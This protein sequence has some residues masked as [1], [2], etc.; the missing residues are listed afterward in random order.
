MSLYRWFF[1]FFAFSKVLQ[2]QVEVSDLPEFRVVD[3]GGA[4]DRD[5]AGF[6]ALEERLDRLYERHRFSVYFVIYSGIIGGTAAEKA[7]DLR[8]QWL[9][10]GVEGLVFVSDTDLG[11]VSFA[12]TNENA[13]ST[14]KSAGAWIL[15]DHLV[16]DA[17]DTALSGGSQYSKESDSAYLRELG[18]VLADELEARLEVQGV[19]RGAS[20]YYL[21]AFALTMLA[22]LGVW[23]LVRRGSKPRALIPLPDFKMN[24]RLGAQYGGGLV[25]EIHYNSGQK[26]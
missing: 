13:D 6:D 1:L 7:H 19:T 2:A 22:M 4:F 9:P 17:I 8:D 5:L 26:D 10:D 15:S 11:Q 12:L 18:S 23:L 3:L 16:L 20:P 21:V 24:S 14:P 25:T